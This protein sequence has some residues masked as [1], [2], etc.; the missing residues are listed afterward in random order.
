MSSLTEVA[1]VSRRVVKYGGLGL[2]VFLFFWWGLTSAVKAYQ[3]AHP[4]YVAPTTYFGV[5]TKIVFPEKTFTKKTFTT[6][7][8]ND[9]LPSFGDQAK[10]YVIY[11]SKSV[12][13]ALEENK[14]TAALLGFTSEPMEVSTGIYQFNDP[15]SNKTLTMNVLENSFKLSYPYLSDQLLQNP[16]EMPS[17][18]GAVTLAKSF[19]SQG[20]LLS[21]DLSNGEQKVSFWKINYNG[22]Q[23]V[24]SLSEANIIRVDFFRKNLDNN[25]SVVS[26]EVGK[27]SVS[28]L[29]SG[30]S[31]SAKKIVE[32]NFKHISIDTS[33]ASSSTYPI[34][35]TKEAITS[36][37]NGNYWPANDTTATSVVI[38]KIYLAYFE[39][40][41][42]TQY[43]KPVYVFEGD[44]GFVAY[45]RAIT[46][47]YSN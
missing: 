2:G 24:N 47:K 17:K 41:D 8:A 38:R 40:V 31:V 34:I 10:V 29:V 37:Q 35:S 7:L 44:G 21:D 4:A 32:V 28:V 22:L 45:V 26:S 1:Y 19:L 3:K 20:N 23:S 16:D 6:E 25:I 15:I 46:D 13:G 39:P 5:L 18:E 36:L 27:A 33:A 30:S 43:L 12:L 11:R 9:T 42:L 14:K